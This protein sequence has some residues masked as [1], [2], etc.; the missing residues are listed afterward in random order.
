[1]QHFSAQNKT[2]RGAEVKLHEFYEKLGNMQH[3][4]AQNSYKHMF[5]FISKDVA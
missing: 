2:S 4:S 1:M 3:Y 5:Y